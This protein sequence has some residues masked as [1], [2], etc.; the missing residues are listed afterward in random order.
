MPLQDFLD[1]LSAPILVIDATI[2]ILTANQAACQLLSKD[3]RIIRN[4]LPGDVSECQN[5]ALP[6]GCGGT[7][8]CSGC[9]VRLTVTD[10]MRTGRSHKEV[11]AYV[12]QKDRRLSLRISTEKAGECVLLRIDRLDATDTE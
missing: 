6:G 3:L 5:A 10:T 7:V 1:G 4:H 2:R 9:A 8:H 12:N 11:P